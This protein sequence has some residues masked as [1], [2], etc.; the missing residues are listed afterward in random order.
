MKTLE[1]V[2]R[3]NEK[4]D[5]YELSDKRWFYSKLKIY[6]LAQTDDTIEIIC[7]IFFLFVAG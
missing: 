6:G 7:C 3:N 1:N 5:V 4:P 2:S